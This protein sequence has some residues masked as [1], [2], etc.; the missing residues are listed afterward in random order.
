[1]A[2]D[3]IIGGA[4]GYD[5]SKLKCWVNS[6]KKSGFRGD[7]MVVATNITAETIQKL[8]EE[9]VLVSAY[10]QRDEN[11]NFKQHSN[12]APH[13][14]RFFYMWNVLNEVKENYVHVITTDTRDVIFQT[15]PSTWLNSY[16]TVGKT[17]VCSSEGLRYKNEPW[18]N[19][20]LHDTFGPYFHNIFKENMIYNVGTIAG[21]FEY[22]RDLLLMIFQMS[23]NRPIPIVD[24]AVFNYLVSQQPFSNKFLKTSNRDAWAA[25]LG[26]TKEA[27]KS[28][29][30]DIGLRAK[31]D[32]AFMDQYFEMYEDIQPFITED[33]IVKVSED[34]P[35]FC[36]VHQYDRIPS[37]NEQIVKRY[38]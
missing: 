26:V 17:V 12:G 8:V 4:S 31:A 27:I 32:P 14:E 23:I 33:G 20:N 22:V 6:I 19:Q 13:V 36:I 38:S 30:G 9:K 16:M 3:L 28:G 7:I 37:L 35:E 15:N 24:Q 21:K 1:M 10:G 25:Q 29:S 2:K 11:G 34:G 18:G 5:W